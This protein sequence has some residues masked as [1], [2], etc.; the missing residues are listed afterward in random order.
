MI[1]VTMGVAAVLIAAILCAIFL[2][3]PSPS[4]I[5]RENLR[6]IVELKSSS[7]NV[8]ESF[9]TA[10]FVDGDGTLVTNAHVVTYTRLNV[11]Y[12]F[13]DYG[14]R[15]ADEDEYRTVELVEYDTTLDIAVLRLTDETCA[16]QTMQ[17]GQSENL[18]SG[19]TVYAIGNAVN[20]GLSRSQGIVGVP[21]LKVEYSGNLRGVIQCDL[22]IAEGNS[23]GALLD[24]RGRLVGIT[25][26]RTKDNMGNVVYGIA[27]CIPIDVVMSFKSD[28]SDM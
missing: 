17:I 20:Y 24:V 26:F 8:G 25:T 4:R 12:T 5:Y 19:D 11:T 27:Y 15:F 28:L 2:P 7:E 10:E 1:F 16:F 22:T 9:G 23:G 6:S 3:L 13:D 21:L 14:I 18:N